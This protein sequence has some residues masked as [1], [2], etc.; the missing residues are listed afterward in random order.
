MS[1]SPPTSVFYRHG[2]PVT[3]TRTDRLLGIDTKKRAKLKYHNEPVVVGD[4]TYDSKAEMRRHR[5]LVLCERAGDIADLRRQVPFVLIPKKRRSDGVM[6]RECRYV[7]DF[8]YRDMRKGGAFV[9]EDVKSDPTKTPDYRIKRKLM[10]QVYDI[11][12]L[13]TGK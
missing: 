6:E 7:A 2:R 5:D 12:I 11:T 3:A 9:V 1:K 13:E 4:Q 8:T 10:L